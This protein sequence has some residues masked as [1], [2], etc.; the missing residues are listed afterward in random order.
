MKASDKHI[1]FQIQHD[2]ENWKLLGRFQ[3]VVT[4]I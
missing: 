4:D 2:P 1:N 3:I